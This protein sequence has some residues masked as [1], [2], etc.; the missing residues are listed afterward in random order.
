MDTSEDNMKPEVD[1]WKNLK[2]TPKYNEMK[3]KIFEN[4]RKR[5]NDPK[6]YSI[7]TFS[8]PKVKSVSNEK[9][10]SSELYGVEQ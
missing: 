9:L 4:I 3:K 5:S 7:K 10:Y 8:N 2:R 1:V 6:L